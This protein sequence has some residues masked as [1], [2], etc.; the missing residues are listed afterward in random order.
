MSIQIHECTPHLCGAA[1]RPVVRAQRKR[2]QQGGGK[3]GSCST[4]VVAVVAIV[5][6]LLLRE[7]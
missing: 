5:G 6:L 7:G 1:T 2:D 3:A 4:R